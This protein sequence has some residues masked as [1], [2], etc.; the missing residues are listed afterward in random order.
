[1]DELE[2]LGDEFIE[3]FHLLAPI[4]ER[5]GNGIYRKGSLWYE[6]V[7]GKS[8][9]TLYQIAKLNGQ[10][11]ALIGRQGVKMQPFPLRHSFIPAYVPFDLTVAVFQIL[12][13]PTSTL[14]QHY[15]NPQH[16]L[17]LIARPTHVHSA[18]V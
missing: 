9:D 16:F 14:S 11:E 10:L 2:Q 15:R 6:L 8:V 7:A 4:L 5:A 18:Q 12:N 1:M 13:L 17:N 3:G